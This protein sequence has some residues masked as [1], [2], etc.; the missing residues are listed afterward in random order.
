MSYARLTGTVLGGSTTYD[1]PIVQ[2]K[3]DAVVQIRGQDEQLR[4]YRLSELTEEQRRAA[5]WASVQENHC[6][7][8][9]MV[10]GPEHWELT[11]EAAVRSWPEAAYKAPELLLPRVLN[12]LASERWTHE[13]G[14]MEVGQ[15]TVP[16]DDRDKALLRGAAENARRDPQYS[17]R[18]KIAQGVYQPLDAA[19][20]IA[21]DEALT[22]HIRLMFA[23]EEHYAVA[24][25]S[26][27]SEQLHDLWSAI[28]TID[29]TEVPT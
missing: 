9:W 7:V 13:V 19:T 5:G 28:P 6:D 29:W 11:D 15:M 22:Q 23:I 21:L 3:P 16:T 27:T 18:W 20:L 1:L 14:G 17:E 8:D 12:R 4:G 25:H 24:A 2:I 26:M 10:P